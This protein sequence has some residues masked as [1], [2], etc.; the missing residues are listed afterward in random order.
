MLW[1]IR[2]ATDGWWEIFSNRQTEFVY[3]KCPTKAQAL[4]IQGMLNGSI[5]IR[6]S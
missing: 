5:Q 6:R 4:M 1:D 2:E 3:A